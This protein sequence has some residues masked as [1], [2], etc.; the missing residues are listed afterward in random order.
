[1]SDLQ[2]A[3]SRLEIYRGMAKW[4]FMSALSAIW[5]SIA[6]G[7]ISTGYLLAL[8]ASNTLVGM[9]SGANSWGNTLQLVTPLLGGRVRSRKVLCASANT[10]AYA[11]WLLVA[12]CALLPAVWPRAGLV[13]ALVVLSGMMLSVGSPA[14]NS[15]LADLVPQ[16]LR[17]R[18]V[19]RNQSIIAAV[20][21]V[22]AL[23]ASWYVDL[24]AGAAQIR[25]FQVA[26][27]G[28]V[29]AGLGAVVVMTR[30]PEPPVHRSAQPLSLAL[31]KLPFEHENFRNLTLFLAA[32]TSA[33]MLAAPLFWVFMLQYLKMDYKFIALNSMAV[34]LST[35]ASN[36]FWGYM[37]DKFGYR[38][39]LRITTFG[40]A[41]IPIPWF[42]MTPENYTYIITP[43]QIWSGVMGAGMVLS[44]YNLMLK[45]A[46][47]EHKEVY[48]GVHNAT[49]SFAM[50]VGAIIGGV[51]TDL[52]ANHLAGATFLGRAVTAWHLIFLISALARLMGL[53][54]LMRVR[55]EPDIA[56][57]VVI[58]QVRRGNVLRTLFHLTRMK[59]TGDTEA[60]VRATRALG[61]P[62]NVL[63]VEELVAALDDS[64]LEVRR[65]AARSL[66]QIGDQRAVAPLIDKATDPVADIGEEAVEALGH[67]AAED[68]YYALIGLLADS[69]DGVRRGAAQALGAFEDERAIAPIEERLPAEPDLSVRLAL[70]E[71]LARLGSTH[72]LGQVRGL[73]GALGTEA[74]RKQ[75]AHAVSY[76]LGDAG[77]F[78][79]LLELDRLDQEER[80][81]RLLERSVRMWRRAAAVFGPRA[82]QAADSI[83]R[84][85]LAF[86]REGY[87]E[88]VV[89]LRQVAAGVADGLVRA[90]RR[91]PTDDPRWQRLRLNVT[92]LALLR[93]AAR[94][95]GVEREGALLAI[96]AYEQV[97]ALARQLVRE[98]ERRPG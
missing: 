61:S 90:G 66:G 83:H 27:V 79:H 26:Y 80:V 75:L 68:S 24:Y 17:G 32:R 94:E 96:F 37:A 25:A 47:A 40:A 55:E 72:A 58:G 67:I 28:A 97:T 93:R 84:A 5:V 30:I 62:G 87:N 86:E 81:A 52:M 82:R 59:R 65:E 20:G 60:R 50:G 16:E 70:I 95:Q 15:W 38:P 54:L 11:V 34:T 7:V 88:T 46:P 10:L 23:G 29:I 49:L 19:G 45:I 6:F 8:G 63:A 13:I 42:F 4:N 56:A 2:P 44:Q 21:M 31:L 39:I 71:A 64:Q 92:V 43:A 53:G 73:V 98:T 18:F 74:A 36:P 12:A 9:L 85:A 89:E 22:I 57:R 51:L 78:Y 35:I 3:L 33:M 69:R 14:A 48:I 77:V 76:L 41:L 1:M 91:W